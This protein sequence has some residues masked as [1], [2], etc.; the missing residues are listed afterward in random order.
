MF[1]CTYILHY[2]I[3]FYRIAFFFAKVS[4]FLFYC[5][6]FL[7][8][9]FSYFPFFVKILKV[10]FYFST[11][12]TFT[13]RIYKHIS[14]IYSVTHHIFLLYLNTHFAHTPT[15]ISIINSFW[16]QK[17]SR[18]SGGNANDIHTQARTTKEMK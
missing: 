4:T 15:T 5:F 1:I 9:L 13:I 12:H 18:K 11:P 14:Y 3:Y 2:N 16:S 6:F 7:L 10:F 17:K 8:L